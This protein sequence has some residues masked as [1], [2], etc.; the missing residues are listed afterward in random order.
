MPYYRTT[1]PTPHLRALATMRAFIE[2]RTPS[3]GEPGSDPE[4]GSEPFEA[5]VTDLPRTPSALS[6]STSAGLG[7]ALTLQDTLRRRAKIARGLLLAA[8]IGLPLVLLLHAAV[9]VS[10]S[11]QA[12]PAVSRGRAIAP[13]LTGHRSAGAAAGTLDIQP[14]RMDGDVVYACWVGSSPGLGVHGPAPT[15]PLYLAVSDDGAFS[16]RLLSSPVARATA[17]H[18][19]PDASDWQRIALVTQLGRDAATG[20]PVSQLFASEDG[21]MRWSAV[22]FPE[23]LATAC[24][25]S[26]SSVSGTLAL[27]TN[28][29]HTPTATMRARSQLW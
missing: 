5:W 4:Q 3:T 8:T 1:T 9:Q 29:A 22:T 17:C 23:G 18:L 2:T 26:L 14:A 21:G 19:V 20:C 12:L 28:Q 6:A 27:W 15:T 16:W 13:W 11:P 10:S 24:T 7:H 25:L